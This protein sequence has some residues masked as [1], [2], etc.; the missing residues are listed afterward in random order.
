AALELLHQETVLDIVHAGTAVALKRGSVEA[1]RA[2]GT[3]ELAWEAAV[4]VALLD[5]GQELVVD[6]GA[7][8]G[9]DRALLFGEQRID[10]EEVDA[11]KPEGHGGIVDETQWRS[12]YRSAHEALAPCAV[13]AHRLF[14][15]V[16]FSNDQP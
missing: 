9:A 4:A 5:D 13:S 2:H 16:R 7:R 10:A 15:A 12:C 6:E 3:D 1:E 11:L 14:F 8:G